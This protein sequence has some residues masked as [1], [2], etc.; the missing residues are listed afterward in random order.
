[1]CP[2]EFTGN[3]KK[4]RYIRHVGAVHRKVMDFVSPD[5]FDFIFDSEDKIPIKNEIKQEI[6]TQTIPR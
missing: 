6:K 2:H 1:M 4:Q 3:G 5:N